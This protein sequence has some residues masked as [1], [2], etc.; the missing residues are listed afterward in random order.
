M[1]LYLDL[2]QHVVTNGRERSDRTGTGT[3][4]VFGYQMRFPLQ[5]GFPIC[6]TKRVLVSGIG[7]RT[8]LVPFWFYEYQA[9]GRSGNLNLDRLAAEALSR[10]SSAPGT[11]VGL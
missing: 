10:A 2:L 5:E 3:I 7:V 4:S 6:T 1:H 11:T 8:A 9:A